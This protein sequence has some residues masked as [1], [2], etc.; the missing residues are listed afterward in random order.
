[1]HVLITGASSFV[2]RHVTA[3]LSGAGLRVTATFRSESADISRL[4][5]LA[6]QARFVRLDLA[7]EDDFSLLPET[8]DTV[9]HIAGVSVMP[10]AT[11][12]D[13]LACN[14]IGTRNLQKY[15]LRANANHLVFASTLSV[16]GEIT[17][18]VVTDATPVRIPD[19][20]GASKYF[21]ER[22]FYSESEHLPCV[23]LRL[24]GVLGPGAHRAW[25]PTM[26]RR[27]RNHDDVAIYNPQ[28]MF[29]NAAHVSDI[30]NL[31]LK[32]LQGQWSGFHAFPVGAA[33]HMSIIDLVN[34]L[35]L[36][37][38]SQSKIKVVGPKK[39]G[40]LVS[41]DYA[42]DRFGYDPMLIEDM[43]HRYVGELG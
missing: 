40:F 10:T 33:G 26:L 43:L 4:A 9:V 24:P 22:L 27:I 5:S 12:D 42:I 6:P 13:M 1:M 19:T 15:A 25:I 16:Y 31:I 38:G 11:V 28:S 3:A 7:R 37:T 41:S 32:L 36:I 8:V 17:E 30:S 18:P 14:V 2:G 23:A 35:V 34:M 39:G 21:A 20:Y 29:N